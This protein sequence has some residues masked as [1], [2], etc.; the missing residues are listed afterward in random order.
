MNYGAHEI[1]RIR[2]PRTKPKKARS[3]KRGGENTYTQDQFAELTGVPQVVARL[4]LD[5]GRLPYIMDVTSNGDKH[6]LILYDSVKWHDAKR[7]WRAATNQDAER[8]QRWIDGM[9][10]RAEEDRKRHEVFYNRMTG[11]TE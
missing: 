8:N 5:A 4:L 11:E 10:Q 6:R 9:A 2:E 3:R 7:M 1:K